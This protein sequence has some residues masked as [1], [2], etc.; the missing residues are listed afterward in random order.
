MEGHL[1]IYI[2]A[3]ML[4]AMLILLFWKYVRQAIPIRLPHPNVEKLTNYNRLKRLGG[5]F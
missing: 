3:L 5:Y 1:Q 2:P 4:V